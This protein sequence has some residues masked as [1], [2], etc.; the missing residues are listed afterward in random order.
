MLASILSAFRLF[1][2]LFGGHSTVAVENLALRQQ[3]A[4]YK[5]LKKRPQMT[6]ADRWFWIMLAPFW[7]KWREALVI[8]HP[9]TVVRWHRRRFRKNWSELSQ[10]SGREPGRP[11]IGVEIRDSI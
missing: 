1:F 9:D 5:R 8:V 11:P 3:S 7:K 6:R 2:V 10:A 4:V